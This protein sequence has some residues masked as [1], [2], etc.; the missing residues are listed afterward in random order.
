MRNFQARENF[1]RVGAQ[2]LCIRHFAGRV[3]DDG[4]LGLAAQAR[5]RGGDA[6]GT[7]RMAGA[8]ITG[9]MFIGDDFHAGN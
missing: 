8:R 6:P 1:R 4:Q 7:F 9:T 2:D 3:P 5:E